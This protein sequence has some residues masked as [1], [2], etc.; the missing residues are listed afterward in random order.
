M[1][2]L[3]FLSIAS[4]SLA[5]AIHADQ[6]PKELAE[7][8]ISEHVS[9]LI[10]AFGSTELEY[11][12]FIAKRAET[13][14]RFNSLD[15]AK[16]EDYKNKLREASELAAKK[17]S[18]ESLYLA[19]EASY[20]F[21]DDP[22]LQS[23]IAS[24]YM[25]L[26]DFKH[27]K[28]FYAEALKLSPFNSSVH[29]NIAEVYFVSGNYSESLKAFTK[30][31]KIGEIDQ[32][33][34][35]LQDLILFKIDL[36]HLGI[37]LQEGVSEELSKTHREAFDQAVNSRDTIK[38]HSLLTYYGYIAQ[39]YA[40]NDKEKVSKWDKQARYVFN[41]APQHTLWIDSLSEFTDFNPSLKN[42][43]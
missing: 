43:Q 20:I 5:P 22:A 30:L 42:G 36:S 29:F 33:L 9:K 17:R 21:A 23:L 24:N 27:A 40:E 1:K 31:K 4:L 35:S 41:K 16:Q 7:A 38:D 13:A 19:L 10:S 34:K 15:P 37:S 18:S 28:R 26:R 14:K 2:I 25:Y 12:T 3:F 32:N 11:K 6:L 39:A 8:N